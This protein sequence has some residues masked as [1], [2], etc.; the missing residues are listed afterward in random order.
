MRQLPAVRDAGQLQASRGEDRP[1]GLVP[2]LRPEAEIGYSRARLQSYGLARR[3]RSRRRGEP[4]ANIVH[5]LPTLGL[6]TSVRKDSVSTG[7][8]S[9]D[10]FLSGAQRSHNLRTASPLVFGFRCAYDLDVLC[11][12]ALKQRENSEKR[13]Q[14]AKGVTGRSTRS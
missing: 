7:Q 9:I 12:C 6:G 8:L 13:G 2:A 4:R 1:E 3:E 14:L 10:P 11:S 5:D